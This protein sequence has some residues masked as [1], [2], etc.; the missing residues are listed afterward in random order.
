LAKC[1]RI[2]PIIAICL[3]ITLVLALVPESASAIQTDPFSEIKEKLSGISEEEKKI[4]QNLFVLAQEVELMEAEEKELA[5]GVDAIN[6]EIKTLE[7]TITQGE[8]EYKRKKDSLEQVLKSYQRMGPGSY[9]EIVLESDDLNT[10]LQRMNILRDLTHNTGELLDQLEASS[11]K[12]SRERTK[13]AARLVQQKEKQALSKAAIAKKMKLKRE[14]EE[15]LASLKGEKEHYQ[16]QLAG[17][18]KVWSELKPIFSEAAN[19][20]S[21]IVAKGSL[22]SDAL[23]ITFSLIDIKGAIDDKVINKVILEQ[24]KLPEMVFS[25]HPGKVEISLPEKH[26]VLSG[27]FVIQDGKI[28]KFQAKEGS[29]F[30]MQ[31]AAGS[32]EELFAEGDLVLDLEPL[33]AGNVIHSVEIK[34]GYLEL[35]NKLDLF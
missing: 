9:V 10:F 24:S 18:Q 15:Y 22:P 13:L 26:L 11:E 8:M 25:F 29:F 4:L 3:I 7:A 20:F 6:R 1:S 31:L 32:L 19:E 28:L 17:I 35:I 21:R 23:R 2:K 12:L 27:I 5:L 30:G 16:E 33:L 14:K 34:E